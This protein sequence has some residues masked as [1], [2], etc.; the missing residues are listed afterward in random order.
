MKIVINVLSIVVALSI[1]ISCK[2]NQG[3]LLL[4]NSSEE[5]ISRATVK[6]CGE[7]MAFINIDPLKSVVGS[8]RVKG[9]SH[10]DIVIEFNNGRIFQKEIGYITSGFDYSH[11]ITIT[12]E[13]I[14]LRLVSLDGSKPPTESV[15]GIG[16]DKLPREM[17][18]SG[19]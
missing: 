6:I 17:T 7:A 1:I 12:N 10:F 15:E 18:N 8:Y 9:D 5:S 11:E 19:G 3:S 2:S 4:V 13:N 14:Y 16:E